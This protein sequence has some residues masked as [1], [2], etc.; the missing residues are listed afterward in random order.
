MRPYQNNIVVDGASN[1]M[2]FYGR[3]ANDFPQDWVQE[4]QVLTNSFGAEFGQAAGGVINVITRSGSNR[5]SGRGYGFFRIR[6]ARQ[7]AVRG[8]VRRN[9]DPVFLDETPPFDQQR[10]GGFLGGPVVQGQALLLRRHREPEPRLVRG[11]WHLGLLAEQPARRAGVACRHRC[12]R[13]PSFPKGTTSQVY[14]AKADWNISKNNRAYFRYTNTNKSEKNVSLNGSA[15]DTAENRYT[16]E[17]PLWNVMANWTSTLSARAFNELRVFY[18]VNKPWILSNFADFKGGS[19]LLEADGANGLN[20]RYPTVS[21]PGANFG[22]AGFTGLEGESNAYIIDNFSFL[23]GKHQLKAGLQLS[24]QTMFMDVEAAHKGRWSFLSDRVFDINDPASVP[25]LVQRQH[26]DRQ[27]D[28]DGVEPG[29]R[30][31]GH[32]AADRQPDAQPRHA[33]R[34]RSDAGHGEPV[35]PGVQRRIVKRLGAS[36]RPGVSS[37]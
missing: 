29:V 1:L 4:F 24:R 20:G 21:Y 32:L 33:L 23:M 22:A 30:T 15:L 37:T 11:P 9:G 3:Q 12:P 6:Q 31:P 36:P 13:I 10:Y 35:H 18:G 17:G 7:P 27:G 2:Q 28:A 25:E 8:T 16:F 14:L 19:Q 5:F 26:R 34:P